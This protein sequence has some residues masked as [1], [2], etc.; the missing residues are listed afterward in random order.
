MKVLL[1]LFFLCNPLSAATIINGSFENV[2]AGPNSTVGI[3]QLYAGGSTGITGWT[4]TLDGVERYSDGQ[5]NDGNFVV[6]LAYFTS[7]RS[8]GIQQIV[9]TMIGEMFTLSF[10]AATQTGGG[11]VGT[12]EIVLMV[13]GADVQT[14]SL[15]NMTSSPVWEDFTYDITATS[16]ATVIEFQNRQN[17]NQHFA[18][19]DGIQ[20]I[21]EPSTFLLSGLALL[22]LLKRRR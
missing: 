5:A 13:N 9:P 6:D 22:G 2:N 20:A 15:N 16:T 10:S 14:Y 4:T 12:A 11:R 8:G 3:S 21:P 1:P 18:L 17:A 7:S 19:I